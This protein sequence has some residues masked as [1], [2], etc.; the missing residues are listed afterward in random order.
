MGDIGDIYIGGVNDFSAHKQVLIDVSRVVPTG[1]DVA[2][3]N[4]SERFWR[5]VA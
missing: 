1:H 2:P 5:R 3:S 4:F